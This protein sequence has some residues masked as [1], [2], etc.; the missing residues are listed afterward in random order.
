[1][2]NGLLC[3]PKMI[4]EK[5]YRDFNFDFSVNFQ[6]GLEWIGESMRELRIPAYYIDKVTDGNA[7]LFHQNFIEIVD[8]RGKLPCDLF[9]ITQTACVQFCDDLPGVNAYIT[10]IAYCDY[11]T[12]ETCTTGDGTTLCNDLACTQDACN[13]CSTCNTTSACDCNNNTQ[14]YSLLPMRW[15]TN[16][17]YKTHHGTNLDYN[18]SSDLTYTVN[19]NYIFTSFK[20]GKVCMAYKAIPTDEEGMPLIPDTQSM[21]NYA[22]WYIANKISFQM[23][24]NGKIQDKVYEEIKG[25]TQL[26]YMKTKNEGKM[27]AS[28]DEWQSYA[29]QRLRFYPDVFAHSKFFKNLQRPQLK[30]NQP[31]GLYGYGSSNN[32]M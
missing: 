2:Y 31:H 7:D 32:I 24:M 18:C 4:F 30:L 3:S 27:P 29:N 13:T 12:G 6:D 26:Y 23:W 22:T 16:T 21:I 17:F 1:M 25:Y 9:S 19:N 10:G 14:H 28:M 8:G 15:N 11:N 5:I 20:E